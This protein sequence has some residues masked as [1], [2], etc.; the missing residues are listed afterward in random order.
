MKL[1]K[2]E[3][4]VDQLPGV[5]SYQIVNDKNLILG[6][7]TGASSEENKA[8]AVLFENA[9]DMKELLMECRSSFAMLT[10]L[11]KSDLSSRMQKK[12]DE[13]LKNMK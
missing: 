3:F 10:L 11:D 5:K 8:M 1:Q 6:I 2:V 12:V 9:P 13:L 4:E 7:A